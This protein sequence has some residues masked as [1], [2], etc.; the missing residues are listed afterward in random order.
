MAKTRFNVERKE[1]AL[2]VRSPVGK[3]RSLAFVGAAGRLGGLSRLE[4]SVPTASSGIHP[5]QSVVP[6]ELAVPLHPRVAAGLVS[7]GIES[8][9]RGGL[10]AEEEASFSLG[11][12]WNSECDAE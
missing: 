1:P 9:P 12:W 10:A 3:G 7:L 8:S 6:P 5:G 11:T 2:A 4:P